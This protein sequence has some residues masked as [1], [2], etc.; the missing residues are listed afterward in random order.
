MPGFNL[1]DYEPVADRLER[2]W[3][4]HPDGRI[5]TELLTSADG[6]WLV[7]A[8]VF[9]VCGDLHPAAVGHA[10]EVV[11]QSGVNRTSAL[12][13]CETSAI[14]RALANCGY[15]PKGFDKRPSRE[16]MVKVAAS[17]VEGVAK[18]AKGRMV[19]RT[20][21]EAVVKA[22]K[23]KVWHL[24][25]DDRDRAAVLWKEAMATLGVVDEKHLT[26]SVADEL[27]AMCEV[28]LAQDAP[29]KV[30]KGTKQ[31]VPKRLPNESEAV[32]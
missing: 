15:A 29:V 23:L 17:Q 31:I 12:E 26:E 4:D 8:A 24:A 9:F 5:W 10:H 18:V 16:E 27:V 22:A 30:T 19:E 13:N 11:G 21:A 28:V 25:G 3:T 6:E 14:G 2:F 32:F 1:D 7:R 20:S